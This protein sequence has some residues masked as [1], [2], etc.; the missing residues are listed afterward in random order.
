MLCCVDR[1]SLAL[2]A[3]GGNRTPQELPALRHK[4]THNTSLNYHPDSRGDKTQ[5]PIR[6]V[7]QKVSGTQTNINFALGE[8]V[9]SCSAKSDLSSLAQ[10]SVTEPLGPRLELVLVE[11]LGGRVIKRTLAVYR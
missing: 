4:T 7:L 6:C 11:P 8:A 2:P 3:S 9:F 5:T 10:R 1:H